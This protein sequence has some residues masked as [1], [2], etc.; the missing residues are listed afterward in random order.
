MKDIRIKF[1]D[2]WGG[3]DP[4]SFYPYKMMLKTGHN[5]ILDDINPDIVFGSVFGRQMDNWSHKKRILYTGENVKIDFNRCDY[6]IG[7]EFSDDQRVLRLPIY[8]LHWGNATKEERDFFFKKELLPTRNKFCA[9][10]HSNSNAS[11]RNDFFF[12]LSQYKKV[13]SGGMAFNNIGY[14]V[15]NK[16]EWLK[17]YKFCMCFENY[18]EY[19]YLT[20][21]LLEGMLGGCI[22]IYWGSESC[23]EE[24]NKKSFINWHEYG[25]D[26]EVIKKIIELDNN[27][28]MYKDVYN[29]PYLIDNKPNEYMSD[30]R[31][32][33]FLKKIFDEL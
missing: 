14:R 17:D 5:I 12:K 19:G 20:E 30:D 2:F 32:I 25:N 9:F 18:S 24:F 3:F 21:K 7:F 22:P 11:K 4:K 23:I 28:D 15:D 31:V 29:Q 1:L 13:D 10:I 6:F 8:Q 16:L 33:N 26:D 27:S